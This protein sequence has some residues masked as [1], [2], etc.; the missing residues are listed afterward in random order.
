MAFLNS[1]HVLQHTHSLPSSSSTS[2]FLHNALSTNFASTSLIHAPSCKLRVRAA[3]AAEQ[4]LT[5]PDL[6]SLKSH[7]LAVVAGLDRGLCAAEADVQAV[8][9]AAGKLEAA[10]GSAVNLSE[11][12]DVLQGRWRLIYSSAFASG[13]LGGMRPGPPVGRLPLTLGQVYQR[14]DVVAKELDNI[15]DLRI[16][17]P[18]PLPPLEVTATLAHTFEIIGDTKIRII[19]E[20][21][22]AKFGGSQ[23]QIP[24]YDLPQLPDFLRPV[25]SLRSG[26]FD[27]I[28]LDKDLRIS[29]GDRGELR[30]F[31][32]S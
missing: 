23:S 8:D 26:E 29:R 21:T 5:L 12:L 32:L 17:T 9:S 6:A 28:Y 14:I 24:P 4:P 13:S 19:F 2:C 3:V 11:N 10:A 15:V 18:W 20:K 30:V 1:H 31:L 25:P 7:L 27:I 16:G 22:S